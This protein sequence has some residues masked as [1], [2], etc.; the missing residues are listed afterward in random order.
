MVLALIVGFLPSESPLKTSSAGSGDG[1]VSMVNLV[2]MLLNPEAVSGVTLASRVKAV[3]VKTPEDNVTPPPLPVPLTANLTGGSGSDTVTFVANRA[4]DTGA[5]NPSQSSWTGNVLSG[6]ASFPWVGVL[7]I[8]PFIPTTANVRETVRMY[9]LANAAVAT[10]AT[11]LVYEAVSSPVSIAVETRPANED[12]DDNGIPDSL[13]GLGAGEV[14]IAN[15][16]TRTVTVVNL[17]SGAKAAGTVFYAPTPNVQIE[18]P[19]KDALVSAGLANASD[20]VFLVAAVTDNIADAIDTVDAG[21]VAEWATAAASAQPAARTNGSP[22]VVLAIVV[23]SGGTF[24]FITNLEGTGLGVDLTLVGLN[25]GAGIPQ[26]YSYPTDIGEGSPGE[27]LL[28]NASGAPNEWSIVNST[29]SGTVLNATLEHFSMFAVFDAGIRIDSV[30]PNRIPANRA[31]PITVTGI[32]PVSTALNLYQAETAYAVYLNGLRAS[33]REG[34]KAGVAITPFDGTNPNQAFLTTPSIPDLGSGHIRIVDLNNTSNEA[35]TSDLF[36][37]V[38]TATVTAS[39]SGGVGSESVT[40]SPTS[41]P[42]LN[43]NEY[44]VG[45]S[46]Q[47]TAAFNASLVQFTGWTLNGSPAGTNNPLSF[48][49]SGNTTLVANFEPICY[50]LTV[51]AGAGGTASAVTP[52]NCSGGR[53][54][55]N[56]VVTITAVPDA[57]FEFDSWTG[58]VANP[59]SATT[60]VLMDSNKTVTATFRPAA[61]CY[62][63]TLTATAG[64]VV[65]ADSGNCPG[66]P[67][68]YSEGTT[69]T[70]TPVPNT[71]FQ[72]VGWAGPNGGEVTGNTILMNSDKS[73]QAVF[74]PI[75]TSTLIINVVGSGTVSP[76]TPAN[77]PLNT[78]VPITASPATGFTFAGWSGP[79]V[80]LVENASSA[81]TT[82]TLS[83]PSVVLVAQFVTQTALLTVGTDGR[84][85]VTVSPTAA[86]NLYPVGTVVTLTATPNTGFV[87]N[88]WIGPN[89]GDLLPNVNTATVTLTMNADKSVVAT[90]RQPL[91]VTGIEPDNAWIF[92]GVVA[93]V[94]GTG[95]TDSTTVN[96]GGQ[97]VAAFRAAEDGTSIEIIVPPSNDTSNNAQVVVGV[98][99]QNGTE[100]ASLPN[101]FTYK[102]YETAGGVNTTAFFFDGGNGASDQPVLTNDNQFGSLDVPQ[103]ASQGEVIYGIVRTSL[104]A[105]LKANT[106]AVGSGV[107]AA[108]NAAYLGTLAP[109]VPLVDLYFYSAVEFKANTPPAGSPIFTDAS[110]LVLANR[111]LDANNKPSQEDALKLTL[112]VGSGGGK[113]GGLTAG[114]VR[115][116]LMTYGIKSAYD[117][118]LNTTVVP[119]PNVIEYQSELLANPAGG[120][121]M[122]VVPDVTNNTPDATPI[123]QITMRL[124]S[125]NGFNLRKSAN[126]NTQVA[127][128][129]RLATPTGTASG[130]VAGGTQIRIVSPLGGLAYV[131]RVVFADAAKAGGTVT[132][133][134]TPSGVDEYNLVLNTPPSANNKG[135]IVDITIYLKSQPNTPAVT[136]KRAFEYK[137]AP[138]APQINLLLLLLGLLVAL[139]GLA[140]G[141]DSGGGGG[142]SCFIATAAYGTPMAAEIDVLRDFRDT[143]LLTNTPGTMFVDAYYHLSPPVA[144]VIAD[145]PL[146][147]ALVRIALAPVILFSKLALAMPWLAFCLAVAVPVIYLARR[148]R[149]KTRA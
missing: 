140:A 51:N 11:T 55:A 26:L 121:P 39:T 29:V 143:Y 66:D 30:T 8:S 146:L 78:D 72:F 137:A 144:K 34:A 76:A 40:L 84:G 53:Y 133:V 101:A 139:L 117:Y 59:S 93:R 33:F 25:S 80:D 27:L 129:I 28:T 19:N 127:E 52:S 54:T 64:G 56:T 147:A 23:N 108:S 69:V 96:L 47:A 86:G 43:P 90:F 61:T 3:V 20:D 79:D 136:L 18:A 125:L 1:R 145:S 74:Q 126:I 106:A 57:G 89:A 75:G 97:N 81:S 16:A 4:T 67:S 15:T 148:N 50:T 123:N 5:F 128:G 58:P 141:G 36:T 42:G 48:T 122:E 132:S 102:R 98:T 68:K 135:G 130:P 70:L 99:V 46:V 118:V 110:N 114:D 138:K 100:T 63:L 124:Y 77:F 95:F 45:D 31:Y 32:I 83:R 92:G 2:D 73:V 88:K 87:F 119:E 17:D 7:D 94:I 65:T 112:P 109:G 113:Q 22:Y 149:G 131:D 62:T 12:G 104:P 91:S 35:S 44:F 82:V 105:V 60:T 6:P 38:A 107:L 10:K 142:G 116:G 21:T 37:V 134:V 49:I 13:S 120:A 115:K 24:S 9:A 111:T 71:G 85:T 14:W 103:V 41:G